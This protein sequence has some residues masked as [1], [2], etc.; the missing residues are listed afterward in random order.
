MSILKTDTLINAI[1]MIDDK[2][3]TEAKSTTKKKIN[4]KKTAIKNY[5]TKIFYKIVNFE[6][7]VQKNVLQLCYKKEKR[8]VL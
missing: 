6:Q 3:I 1:G 7:K 2:Y 8:L 5:S 4:Y